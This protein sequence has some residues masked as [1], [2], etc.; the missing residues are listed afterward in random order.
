[1]EMRFLF[2]FGFGELT[3]EEDAIL[4]LYETFVEVVEN[5]QLCH[6]AY[7]QNH[8]HSRVGVTKFNPPHKEADVP[9]TM[10]RRLTWWRNLLHQSH[11]ARGPISVR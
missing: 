5:E 4:A 6:R 2:D 10:L 9:R 1:M 7:C 3:I 11:L 8:D